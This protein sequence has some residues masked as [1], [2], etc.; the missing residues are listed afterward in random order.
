MVCEKV[1][2]LLL[3][4]YSLTQ[5]LTLSLSNSYDA[6][7]ENFSEKLTTSETL[8]QLHIILFV[9][10]TDQDVKNRM[11]SSQYLQERV[12]VRHIFSLYP[13]VEA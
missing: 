9:Q 6:Q 12:Y 2:L 1:A 7:I 10:Q 5:Q 4:S 11:H 3:V 8:N 13:L